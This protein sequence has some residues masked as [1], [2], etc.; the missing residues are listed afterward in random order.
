MNS[1]QISLSCLRSDKQLLGKKQNCLY[2]GPWHQVLN[3]MAW[4][5]LLQWLSFWDSLT[6]ETTDCLTLLN[7]STKWKNIPPRKFRLLEAGH[8][9]VV[10]FLL[11]VVKM[12]RHIYFRSTT[13]KGNHIIF[14]QNFLFHGGTTTNSMLI[15]VNFIWCILPYPFMTHRQLNRHGGGDP[16]K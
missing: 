6:I 16:E 10:W 7:A 1:T 3:R 4:Q 8:S 15:F 14:S 13:L 2:W 9:S 12:F 5:F 11:L